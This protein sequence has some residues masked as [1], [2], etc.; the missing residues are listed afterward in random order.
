MSFKI[1]DVKDR[2]MELFLEYNAFRETTPTECQ[3]QFENSNLG[4]AHPML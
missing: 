4:A 3:Y 2:I 1:E